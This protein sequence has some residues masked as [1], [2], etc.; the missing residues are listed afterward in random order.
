MDRTIIKLEIEDDMITEEI[1]TAD[2]IVEDSCLML[3]LRHI[4]KLS[5]DKR[6]NAGS[7]TAKYLS[8]FEALKRREAARD[9]HRKRVQARTI[10]TA[11]PARA[12]SSCKSSHATLSQVKLDIVAIQNS[13]DKR[14]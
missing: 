7:I 8:D 9:Q 1:L 12:T 14:R 5:L 10:R 3:C 11:R 13:K 4:S 6:R 2:D